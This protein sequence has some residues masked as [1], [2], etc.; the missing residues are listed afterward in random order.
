[1]VVFGANGILL[2]CDDALEM[3]SLKNMHG[4][5]YQILIQS[6]ILITAFMMI[7]LKGVNQTRLQWLLLTA[8]MISM[9]VY[10]I[11]MPAPPG[12][13]GYIS[14]FTYVVVLIKVVISCF[15]GVYTD[16]Y[17]KVYMKTIPMSVLMTQTYMMRCVTALL[18]TSLTPELWTDGFFRGWDTY[19]I[20]VTASFSVKSTSSFVFVAILDALLKNFA[21]C[22]A[23]IFVFF[24]D[25]VL[26]GNFAYDNTQGLAVVVIIILIVAYVELKK[27]VVK[28]KCYDELCTARH[29][30]ALQ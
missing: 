1:M 29:P 28:A 11:Q 18:L 15:A 16:K 6:K 26:A 4:S 27:I 23:V 5:A 22:V 20:G 17:C 14:A 10:M 19:T 8:L 24:Y 9:S 21:E 3:V 13:A 2:A 12:A 7:P 25:V 30:L